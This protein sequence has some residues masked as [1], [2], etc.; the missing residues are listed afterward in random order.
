MTRYAWELPGADARCDSHAPG[1][2]IHW[3][4]FNWSMRDPGEVIPV[5]ASVDDDGLVSIEGENLSLVLWNHHP[6]LLRAALQRFDGMAD[7][8]P[9]W[10]ILAVPAETFM[11]S[12]RSVFHLAKPD[13]RSEC[14]RTHRG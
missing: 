8:K 13:E 3:V 10:R 11:G 6:D 4:Q 9:R 14:G 1:H 7:W 2:Q 12:P 5:T